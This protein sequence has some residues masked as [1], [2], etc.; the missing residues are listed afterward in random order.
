MLRNTRIRARIESWISNRVLLGLITVD[1]SIYMTYDSQS[2]IEILHIEFVF[3]DV[4]TQ[5]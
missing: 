4:A 3:F 1:L 2:A 5:N